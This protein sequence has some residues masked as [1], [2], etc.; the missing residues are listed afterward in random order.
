[1]LRHFLSPVVSKA[2]VVA[3][4]IGCALLVLPTR[5]HAQDASGGGLGQGFGAQGQIAISGDL[6]ASFDKVNHG[7][8]RFGITP[9]GDY[10]LLPSVSA[11]VVLGV[12]L[13]NGSYTEE[14]ARARLGYNL[15]VTSMFGVWPKVGIAYDHASSGSGSAK[16][17]TSTTWLTVDAPIMVHIVPHLFVGFGPYYYLKVAGDSNT[18]FGAHSVVGGWF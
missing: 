7:G 16:V 4:V 3:S 12:V 14:I 1:M 9:A 17:T 6:G 8:W 10:F 13:G 5:A 18:G 11:G 15:N 2:V